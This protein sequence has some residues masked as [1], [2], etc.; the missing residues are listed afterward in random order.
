ME[1]QSLKE[2]E[3]ILRRII[4][5]FE[6]VALAFSGGTDSSLL[7]KYCLEI[8]GKDRVAAFISSSPIHPQIEI[9]EAVAIAKD[10]GAS[11]NIIQTQELK[12]EEFYLNKNNYRCY[13]CKKELFTNIKKLSK[14]KGLAAVCDG[15]NFNDSIHIR[16]SFEAHRQLGIY[17]PLADARLYK[18]EIREL[19]KLQKLST[20]DKKPYSCYAQKINYGQA[21]TIEKIN[22]LA[23][24][25]E[26]IKMVNTDQIEVIE[27]TDHTLCIRADENSIKKL[28][29]TELKNELV[30]ELK[31]IG[32]HYISIDLNPYEPKDY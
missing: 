26:K 32:Y 21:I 23:K 24:A 19:S 1:E 3:A 16:P 8:L 29:N 10:M 31:E 18:H 4:A 2:K 27:P 28:L 15:T 22:R 14:Q 20:W 17:S 9:N 5:D 13:I 25:E 30:N 12:I 7:L 6:S 11:L